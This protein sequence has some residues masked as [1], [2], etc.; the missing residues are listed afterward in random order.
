[1]TVFSLPEY[2]LVKP[3]PVGGVSEERPAEVVLQGKDFAALEQWM[4]V[5]SRET[6]RSSESQPTDASRVQ[7]PETNNVPLVYDRKI[8][9][10]LRV[11]NYAG[12][13]LLP[14]GD[15]FEILPK[16]T[17]YLDQDGK[18]RGRKILLR[19]LT[20]VWQL[21]NTTFS[22]A[23]LATG[24]IPLLEVFIACFLNEVG[25]LIRRGICSG[26]TPVE[27][28]SSCL[29][30]KLL[31]PQHIRA[32][33][34]LHERFFVG[35]DLYLPDR[36]ENRLIKVALQRVYAV[37]KSHE[38][39]RRCKL[40]LENFE[41]VSASVN[42][43]ADMAATT[44]QDRNI[45]H[46]RASLFWSRLLLL[47]QT[48]VPS[49][50]NLRCTAVLFPM[51]KLFEAYVTQQVRKKLGPQGWLTTPQAQSK[52]L[53][54]AHGE[55]GEP[56][57]LLK[58]DI[59]LQRGEK[60]VIADAKWKN[61]ESK[62]TITTADLYQL[63]AYSEKYLPR[64]ESTPQESFLLYP[65]TD[66]FH[67]PFAPFHYYRDKAILWAAPYDLETDACLLFDTL[68]KAISA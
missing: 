40:F 6:E 25:L 59:L 8:R 28:N 7:E 43:R 42:V 65:K 48:P 35:Y 44:S 18:V 23:A 14:S 62:T 10:A 11:Q 60:Y 13:V 57:S 52:H 66:A 58:P 50:G 4:A 38:S 31:L 36:P 22:D 37:S 54:E 41:D 20:A 27:E 61:I 9:G 33:S 17:K 51:E 16:I 12:L 5:Q 3:A 21:P 30:G 24:K 34:F 49:P 15:S 46:Y 45:R 63:F 2:G 55:K 29:R 39:K 26:Y 1:M 47:G 67:E 56:Y 68:G 64:L 53:V 32:N 19:M